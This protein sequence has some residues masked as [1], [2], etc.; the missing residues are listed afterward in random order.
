MDQIKKDFEFKEEIDLRL[1]LRTILRNKKLIIYFS[2]I[3]AL[4]TFLTK[5]R[6]D[7]I[8]SGS[9]NILTDDKKEDNSSILSI[10][11]LTDLSGG[12]N[13]GNNTQ[14]SLILK[15][16]SVLMP[17]FNFVKK[18]YQENGI[19]TPNLTFNKWLKKEL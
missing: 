14:Q 11:S 12:L 6:E 4:F 15:S 19:K 9:F 5:S 13:D 16:E 1:I 7:P 17:V 10:S 3:I 8:F 2:L 18:N